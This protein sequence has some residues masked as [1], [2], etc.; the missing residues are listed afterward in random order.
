MLPALVVLGVLLVGGAASTTVGLIADKQ[1]EEAR[2]STMTGSSGSAPAADIGGPLLKG[3]GY[4]VQLPDGWTD[5]TA[6]F[7]RDNPRLVSVDRVGAWG[8][9]AAEGRASVLIETQSAEGVT[10]LDILAGRWR[11]ALLAGDRT[12]RIT[13]EPTA[14]ID[15]QPALGV[16][17]TRT[18]TGGVRLVQRAYLVVADDVAYSISATVQAG[19]A[20]A[21][22]AY[23]RILTTWR[24]SG[25]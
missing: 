14:D 11:S 13:P 9:T 12:A 3:R 7:K 10:D 23:G 22:T 25:A 19:D 17:V 18:V 20:D 8:P 1:R 6:S 24:W 16:L 21:L 4:V 15:G 2:A 5:A